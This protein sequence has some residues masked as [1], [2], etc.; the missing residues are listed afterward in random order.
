MESF[1]TGVANH[2]PREWTVGEVLPTHAGIS[3]QEVAMTGNYKGAYRNNF[4]IFRQLLAICKSTSSQTI[5]F[6]S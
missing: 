1:T 5:L 6:R 2:A 4:G 3:A